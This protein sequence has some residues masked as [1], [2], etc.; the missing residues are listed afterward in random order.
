MSRIDDLELANKNANGMIGELSDQLARK[1]ALLNERQIQLDAWHSIF[2]TTQL[3]HAQARL[4]KAES[5]LDEARKLFKREI[6]WR[7]RMVSDHLLH[8]DCK[9]HKCEGFEWRADYEQWLA[10]LESP[11]KL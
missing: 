5:L 9:C 1:Q 4:E 6:K 10:K 7:M 8:D 3:T 2:G 11:Q